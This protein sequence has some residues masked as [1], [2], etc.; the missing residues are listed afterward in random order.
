MIRYHGNAASLHPAG[1]TQSLPECGT[2]L[3]VK[4]RLRA[5]FRP[6][7]IGFSRPSA[8]MPVLLP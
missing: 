2:G 5:T 1:H 6:L 3:T 8:P 4:N 7:Q